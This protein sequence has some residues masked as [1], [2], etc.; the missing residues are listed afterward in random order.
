MQK[1]FAA[2]ETLGQVGEL[3]DGVGAA[4]G[5]RGGGGVVRIPF[6]LYCKSGSSMS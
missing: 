5:D 4:H 2:G 3:G 1:G 6:P